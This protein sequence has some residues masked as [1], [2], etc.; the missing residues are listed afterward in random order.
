MG[1]VVTN[2]ELAAR[3][4]EDRA[5]G[6]TIAFANGCFDVLHVGHVRYLAGAAREADRL[7]VAINDDE[8]E[9]ALKGEGRPIMPATARAELVAA[10]RGVDYVVLFGES[11]VDRLLTELKPDVH[12]KGTD[13][14]VDTVPERETV[15]AYGGRIAIVGDP[16]DHS[17]RDLLSRLRDDQS[18]ARILIV[19][20]GSLG[21]LVHTLPA[22]AALRRRFPHATIDWLVDAPHRAFLELVPI[23][24]SLI[25]LPGRTAAAWLETRRTLRTR[26]YD[27]ALDFQGLLKS[28]ALARL[29]GAKRVLGFERSALREGAAAPL[30]TERVPV[31]DSRHVIQKNLQLAASLIGEVPAS[32]EFPIVPP[33]SAVVDR[34]LGETPGPFALINP[35]A[36]W[37]NKRWPPDRLAAIARHLRDRHAMSSV[38][39]W[40]PGEVEAAQ[41]IVDAAAGAARLAPETALPDLVALAPHAQLMVSGDT[42]P[43]HI[44]S[45]L[46]VPTVSLFGPTN[47]ARNG[48]WAADDIAVAR[49]DRCDCHYERQCRHDEGRWCLATIT[50]DDVIAAVDE[51]LRRADRRGAGEAGS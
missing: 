31:D 46:G 5:A 36:A 7:I 43:L 8:S 6:R 4:A 35:G 33:A 40:G 3:V 32:L 12:C 50:V 13:Y 21:D 41:A 17:T 9:R 24:S 45:A 15:R 51:R 29:S 49:Y 47:P 42:G 2:A 28:A 10:L 18:I 20:L 14:R 27:V 22:V 16:K 11:S 23:V 19:R 26:D 34:F 39:L 38:I 25:V 1:L 44:A 30:Y 48:P 37:P